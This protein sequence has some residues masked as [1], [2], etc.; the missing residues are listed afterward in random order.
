M[1]C[2]SPVWFGIIVLIFGL[3]YILKDLGYWEFFRIN[4][5]SVV[6]MLFGVYMLSS[7]GRK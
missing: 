5:W 1:G 7:V 2:K 6:L 4:M 3:F